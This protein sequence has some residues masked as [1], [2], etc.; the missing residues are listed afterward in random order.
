MTEIRQGQVSALFRK[1][2][3]GFWGNI[4]LAA[5]Y[6]FFFIL[7][8]PGAESEGDNSLSYLFVWL[9]VLLATCLYRRHITKQFDPNEHREPTQLAMWANKH[10][11]LT[12][13]INTIWGAAGFILVYDQ[14]ANHFLI[15]SIL[16]SVLML[17]ANANE[18]IIVSKAAPIGIA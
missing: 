8:R 2:T 3:L 6:S 1:T 18:S 16:F 17:S 5:I 14:A 11:L 15:V 13:V 7:F 10:I 9:F 12:T 4:I